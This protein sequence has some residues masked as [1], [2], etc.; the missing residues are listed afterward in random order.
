MCRPVVVSWP[1]VSL[2]VESRAE[3]NTFGA[4]KPKLPGKVAG[5][6]ADTERDSEEEGDDSDLEQQS[7]DMR[8]SPPLPVGNPSVQLPPGS[9]V[10]RKGFVPPVGKP[11]AAS[12][13]SVSTADTSQSSE[14][15]VDKRLKRLQHQLGSLGMLNPE[16]TTGAGYRGRG[17]G[18]TRSGGRGGRPGV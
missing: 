14:S 1:T 13:A 10:A 16:V 17:G 6:D 9:F 2:A 4:P 3:N 11:A 15:A 12:P 7:V 5:A 18:T 8:K